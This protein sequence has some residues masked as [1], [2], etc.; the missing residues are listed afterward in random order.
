ME[1]YSIVHID[2]W[3]DRENGRYSSTLS[4]ATAIGLTV[5]AMARYGNIDVLPIMASLRR[6]PF[7]NPPHDPPSRQDVQN[8]LS[9]LAVASEQRAAQ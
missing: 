8:A 3:W 4:A 7:G 2:R 6:Q 5:L 9:L 1:K